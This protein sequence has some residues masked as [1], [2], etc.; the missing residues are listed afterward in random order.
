MSTTS[1]GGGLYLASGG[2]ATFPSLSTADGTA[3][4]PAYSFSSDSDTGMYRK[5]ANVLGFA[6]N[7]AEAATISATVLKISSSSGLLSFGANSLSFPGVQGLR[8]DDSDTGTGLT[9]SQSALTTDRTITVPDV[10][11][12]MTVLG[13]TA[14]GTGS[15]VRATSPTIAT[16]TLTTPVTNGQRVAVSTKT[17]DY[18]L[19]ATDFVILVDSTGGNVTITL[20]AASTS[21][22]LVFRIKRI[23]ASVNGVT[24]SRAGADTI[25]GATSTALLTQYESACIIGLTSTTF[26]Q[27]GS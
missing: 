21:I 7:G 17:A 16:P 18:T 15:I 11:G 10:N 6:V 9:F 13:N 2:G 1:L 12:T 22:G 20:P 3:P 5:S 14:T 23:D 27:F 25:D 26:G 8:I 24:I 19:T 4:A